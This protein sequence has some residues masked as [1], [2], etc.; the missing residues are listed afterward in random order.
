MAETSKMSE[1]P[2]IEPVKRYDTLADRA[3]QQLRQALMTGIFHP[4]QKLTI[5]KIAAVL[6]VS[7]TPARDAISRLLSE[8]V[9]ESD[10]NRNVFAPQLDAE[11]LS[12]LYAMRIALEGLAA[13]EGAKRLPDEKVRELELVQ[14]SLIA[15]MDRQDY[16]KVLIENEKFH[17]GIYAESGNH[18]LVEAIEQLWLKLGPT[19]NLLYPSYNHS[20]TGVVHHLAV[21]D[22]LRSRQPAAVRQAIEQDL[23]DGEVELRNALLSVGER[24]EKPRR[25][26][27]SR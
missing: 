14:M 4:G 23:R 22:A 17:F 9:L 1:I 5:R 15:A 21:V 25:R 3:Y 16:Q 20:R 27:A 11:K 2:V 8:R 7:A 10:A 12:H 19:M 13:E 24:P 18:M 26:S 6:G